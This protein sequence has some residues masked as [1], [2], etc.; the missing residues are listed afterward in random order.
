MAIE[1]DKE[2]TGLENFANYLKEA[3]FLGMVMRDEHPN[4]DF[5]NM[6]DDL[7]H[8]C[9]KCPTI[10]RYKSLEKDFLNLIG[11]LMKYEMDAMF[12]E[13]IKEMEENSKNNK[14]ED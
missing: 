10:K 14:N 1:L 5:Y 11:K 8:I 6:I 9:K 13:V 3:F 12:D 7:H 2:D 4:L